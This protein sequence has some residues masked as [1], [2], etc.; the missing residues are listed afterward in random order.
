MKMSN[1]SKSTKQTLDQLYLDRDE[2]GDITFIVDSQRIRAH[3]WVLAA[4]SPKFKAQFYGS[5]PDG[6]EIPL[7]NVS[8]S[9]FDEFLQFFYKESITLTIEN[10][11]TVLDLAKQ[12]LVDE[13]VT[14]CINFIESKTTLQNVCWSYR[15]AVMYGIES[16][17]NK[18]ER[19][20]SNDTNE[21]FASLAF[22]KCDHEIL[23]QI[24]KLN[25]M[26]CTEKNV[27]DACL[28][29]AHVQ[30]KQTNLNAKNP[31]NLRNVL[32]DAIYQLRF[33]SMSIEE[34]AASY[35]LV[36]GLFMENE[37][38][39]ILYMIGQLDGFKSQKFNQTPR[40]KAHPMKMDF[41]EFHSFP[42]GHPSPDSSARF[43]FIQEQVMA[44]QQSNWH[45][46][47]RNFMRQ[48]YRHRRRPH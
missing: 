38:V 17:R 25:V 43:V 19:Q 10:I 27:F 13:F 14:N 46:P 37:I 1:N 33:A 16:L 5:H 31:A 36:E 11:E 18:C 4:A 24:L 45:T 12:S 21:L 15:L 34:F 2:T 42:A 3:R 44:S 20:I 41:N 40:V 22:V 39:E 26:N 30:C 29:W 32:G 47:P 35:K 9:A 28:A 8:A 6:S 7:P 23:L 48:Q